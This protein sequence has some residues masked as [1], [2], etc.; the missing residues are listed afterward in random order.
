MSDT[1]YHSG[2]WVPAEIRHGKITP[3][4]FE[5]LG[6]A[7][8]L[9]AV[10]G[11][12]VT[13]L[14][15]GSNLYNLT[16]ELGRAGADRVLMI[17][18]AR[19]DHFRD[20][21]QAETLAKL[22]RKHRP[23]IVLLQASSTGRALAPRVAA[24]CHTG[25]TA[26][27]T[28]LAIEAETGSLLQTRPAFG[29]SLLAT[30]RTNGFFPQMSTVRPGVMRKLA[31]AKPGEPEII[32][33][34]APVDRWS[35]LKTVLASFG[36]DG[37]EPS[38]ESAEAIVAGGRGLDREAFAML[39]RFAGQSGVAVGASRAA[40]DG[41]L[42]GYP[43][44]IG[45]T[46]R[47]VQTKLYIAFGISGQIQHLVGMQNCEVLVAVNTDPEAPLMKLADLAIVGDA[48]E[49]LQQLIH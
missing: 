25:L 41:N 7:V 30:I 31:A 42:I 19:F 29:G 26:D 43:H 9:A 28:E 1:P 35:E 4:T 8:K 23:A 15:W 22:I 48:K 36:L 5:L 24:L 10:N 32:R 20:E 44:Q 13:A 45:Q 27:C 16:A 17:E 2:I 11:D 37:N 21:L 14:L 33:E 3:A 38:F 46:G 39:H 12:R 34:S 6:E 40:V 47:T 18:D 49:I